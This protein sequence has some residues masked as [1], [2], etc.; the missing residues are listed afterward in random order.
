VIL[1]PRA[2]CRAISTLFAEVRWI[3]T[4]DLARALERPVSERPLLLDARTPAEHA[5]SHLVGARR[6][7]PDLADLDLSK[8]TPLVVYCSVG[9]RSALACKHLAQ[10]GYTDVRNLAGGIFQWANEGRPLQANGQAAA[11]V[12]PFSRLWGLWLARERRADV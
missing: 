5:L 3:E 6:V 4:G 11:R 12:H 8:D 10:L 9:Y 1:Q 7:A 2:L